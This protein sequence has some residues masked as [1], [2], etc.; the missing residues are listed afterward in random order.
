L[1]SVELGYTDDDIEKKTIN[2]VNGENFDPAFLKIVRPFRLL[3]AP[4]ASIHCM[5]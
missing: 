1:S 2:L 4:S 3:P 5:D